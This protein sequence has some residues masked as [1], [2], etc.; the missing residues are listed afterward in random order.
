MTPETVAEMLRIGV[1]QRA[2]LRLEYFFCGDLSETIRVPCCGAVTS[3][4]DLDYRWPAGF[5]RFVLE[6]SEPTLAGTLDVLAVTQLEAILGQGC[7]RSS[8]ATDPR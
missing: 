8:R 2:A 5:A 1:R 6:A 3:L 4:S 7:V